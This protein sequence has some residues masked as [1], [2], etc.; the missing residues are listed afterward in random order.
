MK[1]C[2]YFCITLKFN[3]EKVS[4]AVRTPSTPPPVTAMMLLRSS[5][6]PISC[7]ILLCTWATQE[8]QLCH[9]VMSAFSCH[10]S[11]TRR[12][13]S[14]DGG[15]LALALS[16]PQFFLLA[17]LGTSGSSHTQPTSNAETNFKY[18]QIVAINKNACI[19]KPKTSCGS[20]ECTK[21]IFITR[22]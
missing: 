17:L 2:K 8:K 14:L 5:W 16:S 18:F 6:P 10:L 11:S 20:W 21:Y 13:M 22:S 7:G 4:G 12:P 19:K 9:Q 3:D 15:I 1:A